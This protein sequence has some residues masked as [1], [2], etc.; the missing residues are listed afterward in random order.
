MGLGEEKGVKMGIWGS[1]RG[2][3]VVKSEFRAGLGV[4]VWNI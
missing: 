3:K 1:F 2:K 4:S